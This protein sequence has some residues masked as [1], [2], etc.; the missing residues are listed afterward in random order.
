M[1]L[2]TLKALPDV[3]LEAVCDTNPERL[4]AFVARYAVP[5]SALTLEA[6]L[7]ENKSLDF[8]VVATPGYTHYEIVKRLLEAHIHIFVEKPLALNL[9]EAID[10]QKRA[11]DHEVKVCVG[12]TWR[13]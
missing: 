6:F 5:K 1:H 4:Q 10:L 11:R 8:V 2:P 9:I 7:E 12:Q 3:Q 13:F